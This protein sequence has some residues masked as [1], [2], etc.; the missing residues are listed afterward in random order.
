[1]TP[2][3]ELPDG[4]FAKRI[5]NRVWT[6]KYRGQLLIHAGTS[7]RWLLPGSWPG[8]PEKKKRREHFPEMQF[9]AIVGIASLVEVFPIQDIHL[10]TDERLRAGGEY[11]WI[12][13]HPHTEGPFCWVLADVRR[14]RAPV[15]MVGKLGLF[16][17][18]DELVGN[19]I[20]NSVA[21]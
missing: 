18:P 6:T 4:T 11:G 8:T 19:A 3:S 1:M 12:A 20:R 10:E 7:L 15:P 14:F 17:V 9:G 21:V 2:Q 16:D 5:E 13:V